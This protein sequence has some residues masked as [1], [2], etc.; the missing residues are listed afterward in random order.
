MSVAVDLEA[1]GQRI[2]EFGPAAFLVTV[3][4][5]GAPHVVSVQVTT[6]GA[7]LATRVGRHTSANLL[8]LSLIH[9]SE[10]TRPY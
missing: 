3:G 10:P 5:G 6:D 7:R 8:A 2:V 4:D 1:L 9:I